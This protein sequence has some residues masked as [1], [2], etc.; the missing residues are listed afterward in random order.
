MFKKLT[1]AMGAL[2]TASAAKAGTLSEP[3]VDVVETAEAGSSAGSSAGGMIIPLLLLVAVVALV[4][5]NDSSSTG[6]GA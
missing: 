1:I 5:G 6:S 2:F 4:A 3:M